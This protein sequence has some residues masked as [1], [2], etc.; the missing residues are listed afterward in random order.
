MTS[1]ERGLR[2]PEQSA[3]RPVNIEYNKPFKIKPPRDFSHL[4]LD[5]L[6][7]WNS[8]DRL[9]TIPLIGNDGEGDLEIRAI[10]RAEILKP[11]QIVHLPFGK[12]VY[13]IKLDTSS[14]RIMVTDIP[15]RFSLKF[16]PIPNE[17]MDSEIR[18]GSTGISIL[19]HGADFSATDIYNIP[20]GSGS[21]FRSISNAGT[22]WTDTNTKKQGPLYVPSGIDFNDI[23]FVIRRG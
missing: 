2:Q 14:G 20:Y 6:T 21:K 23:Q 10:I 4:D 11:D 8:S 7:K 9:V 22:L 18:D 5:E 1:S 13:N 19:N 3:I 17:E 16:G 12:P 15:L